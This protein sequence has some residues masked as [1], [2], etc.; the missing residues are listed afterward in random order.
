M[1]GGALIQYFRQGKWQLTDVAICAALLFLLIFGIAG[2]AVA[3]AAAIA[4]DFKTSET[5]L[6]TGALMSQKTDAPNAV[7]LA[8]QDNAQR[9]IGVVGDKPL[10]SLTQ[11][12]NQSVQVVTNGVTTALVSDING[13]V[14]VGDNITASAIAGV[15]MK[16]PANSVV[17]GTAQ[18]N[19]SDITTNT[20]TVTDTSGAKMHTVKVGSLPVQINITFYVGA[21]GQQS[22]MP[23]FIQDFSNDVAGKEVSP[24]RVLIA[25]IILMLSFVSIAILLY[26]SVRS[27]IIS[28]GRNPLS[29]VSVRKS[30]FQIGAIIIGVLILTFAAIYLILLT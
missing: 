15:G 10:I 2:A 19:L 3:N 16:A 25:T 18:A 6:A 30:L 17:I 20:R 11:S 7:E 23:A 24:L 4:Q 5:N 29:E 28:I 21:A 8:T 9:L 14:K 22:Y 26:A 27:S 12:Q 1:L 13:D